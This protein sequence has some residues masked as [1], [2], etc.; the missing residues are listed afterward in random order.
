MKLLL[1][2]QNERISLLSF[3]NFH[4][5]ELMYELNRDIIQHYQ[6]IQK[7]DT[8]LEYIFQFV[9]FSFF[10]SFYT[11][12]LIHKQENDYTIQSVKTPDHLKPK[13]CIQLETINDT[14]VILGTDHN[15][16]IE[17]NFE[18]P[19]ESSLLEPAV[20]HMFKKIVKRIKTYIES[21]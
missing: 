12:M 19:E 11:H 21:L 1:N 13:N 10:P 7:T 20:K 4:L 16:S 18:L 2:L 14:V 17:F 8:T 6:C 15:L 9:P 3:I 5:W